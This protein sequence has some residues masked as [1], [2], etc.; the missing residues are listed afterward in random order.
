MILV[1]GGAGYIG[2]HT[3]IDLAN[4]GYDVLI[5]DN[6]D[7]ASP[8]AVESIRKVT[9]K[10]I[11][12]VQI[13]LCDAQALQNVFKEYKIDG[14][15]HF[16]A[17]KSV[18]ESVLLPLKYFKNN[19][20]GLINL[21]EMVEKYQVKNF[22]FSSSC[23]V[24]GNTSELPVTEDTALS[25]PECPYART[26]IMGEEILRDI[27]LNADT[28]FIALRYFNPA[29]A[30]PSGLL[31]ESALNTATNLVPV[32]C[33]TGAGLR[34]SMT[35]FG[36]DYPTRDGSCIRDYIHVMDLAHAHT[37]ALRYASNHQQ[38]NFSI[39]NLGIGAGVT[40]LEAIHAFEL[41][42]GQKLNY[43]LGPRRD[44]DVVEIY[45]DYTKA[46]QL[47]GWTPQH[48]IQSIMDTAWRW[49]LNKLY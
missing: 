43:I 9:N 22:I 30:H 26:K 44:G 42:S 3:V 21:L 32:I 24:Y 29:G 47:L 12:F 34:E 40:V 1:T 37:L 33:E 19:L 15:I 4:N 18:N 46:K 23:S 45:A 7:N 20:I 17:H 6:L 8:R 16:A 14:I 28:H 41:T 38:D 10:D 27:S 36:T 39:F 11:P 13:D 49:Q 2:S 25:P 31:G 48:D 35:V 5:L